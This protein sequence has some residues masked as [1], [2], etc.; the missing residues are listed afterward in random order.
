MG[1]AAVTVRQHHQPP[2]PAPCG[3]AGVGRGKAA[4]AEHTHA[5]KALGENA[6]PFWIL[7]LAFLNK[8]DL[9]GGAS[10]LL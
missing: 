5:Q 8:K 6:D 7:N 1:T 9:Y 10:F 2:C 4:T 3:S